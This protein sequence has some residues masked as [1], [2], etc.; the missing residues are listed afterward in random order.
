[1]RIRVQYGTAHERV[2]PQT[3]SRIDTVPENSYSPRLI[4]LVQARG[5]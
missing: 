1:M 5:K 3:L 2:M 4:V